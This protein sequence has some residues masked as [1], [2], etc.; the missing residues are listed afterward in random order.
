MAERNTPHIDGELI[1]IGVAASA[2]VEAGNLVAV[3]ADGYLVHA[4]DSAGLTVVG[5][6]EETKDNSDGADGALACLVRRKRAFLMENSATNAVT[7]AMVGRC[8]YV[9]DSV[10]V[11]SSAATNDVVAGKCLAVGSDGVLVEIPA[12]LPAPQAAT[13]ADSE[14]STVAGVVTDFNALLAKLQAA[15]IMA[16]E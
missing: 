2:K 14:A 11:C 16:S 13:Q 4:A 5:M 15:G 9:E 10:T 7:Q 6:A 3:D 12:T 8:V 1:A